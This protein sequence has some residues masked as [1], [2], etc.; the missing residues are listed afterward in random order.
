MSRVIQNTIEEASELRSRL[1]AAYILGTKTEKVLIFSAMLMIALFI[2]FSIA[3]ACNR[4]FGKAGKYARQPHVTYFFT[5]KEGEKA[6][7]QISGNLNKY[8]DDDA[9]KSINELF[10]KVKNHFNEKMKTILNEQ[11]VRKQQAAA[12]IVKDAAADALVDASA[13]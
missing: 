3:F 12:E 4:L 9:K 10:A 2:I 11:A 13:V 1:V 7:E 8:Y 5:G 6:I